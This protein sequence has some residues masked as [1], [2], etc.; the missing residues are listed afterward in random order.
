[1]YVCNLIYK[2]RSQLM[3]LYNSRCFHGDD[4]L[5][6]V[7]FYGLLHHSAFLV[8]LKLPITKRSCTSTYCTYVM[9]GFY[10]LGTFMGGGEG[11]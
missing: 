2:K 8:S 6:L 9:W 7:G 5:L 4:A 10:L 11:G 1:M 3:T